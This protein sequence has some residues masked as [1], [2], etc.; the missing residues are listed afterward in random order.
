MLTQIT[1]P[2]EHGFDHVRAQVNNGS[3]DGFARDLATKAFNQYELAMVYYTAAELPVYDWLAANYCVADHWFAAHAGSTWPNRWA[4]VS[5]TTPVLDNFS[6]DDPRLGFMNEATI[7]DA[8]RAEQIPFTYFEH[9]VSVLRMFNR[10]PDRR[11]LCRSVRSSRRRHK[12]H[13]FQSRRQT[14]RTPARRLH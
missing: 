13:R 5:G 10:V 9:N 6:I 1:V 8:L 14:W 4:T 7:F 3:M 12:R 11:H 2:P